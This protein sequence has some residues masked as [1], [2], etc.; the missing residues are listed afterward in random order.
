[1]CSIAGPCG[2]SP[3]LG[4]KPFQ[5]VDSDER[6]FRISPPGDDY[7]LPVLSGALDEAG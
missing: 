5:L 7:R 4:I 1:M 3:P 2:P 6:H